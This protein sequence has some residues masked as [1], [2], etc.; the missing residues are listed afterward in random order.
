MKPQ[1]TISILVSDRMDTLEKCLNSITPILQN[2]NSELILVLTGKDPAV[3]EIAGQYTSHIIPFTWCDDFAEARNAGLREAEGEWFL[4]LD[5]D[6]WFEDTTEIIQFF[7]SGEYLN[8]QSATY[9]VRNYTDLEGRTYNDAQVSRMCRLMPDTRFMFPVHECLYPFQD[10][11]KCLGSYVHHFGYARNRI[12]EEMKAKSERN[13]SILLKYHAQQPCVHS[14]MQLAQEY[15]YVDD[16]PTAIEY[17][18]EGLRLAER[19]E[20]K[21]PGELWMQVH[22][23]LML[24][25]V[26][27]EKEAL[28]EGEQLL[29]SP[30]VLEVGR[31]NLHGILASLCWD[32]K[33]YEKGLRHVRCLRDALNCLEKHPKKA[34]QQAS[35]SI[36]YTTAKEHSVSAYIAGLFFA[37]EMNSTDRLQEILT[38]LPWDEEDILQSRYDN[39]E[40]LKKS[41]P[42]L[43]ESILEGYSRIQ[44]DNV[45][46][47]LQ[48]ALYAEKNQ[49]LTEAEE[50]FRVCAGNCPSVFIYQ[51][52]DLAK[53]NGFPLNPL[54]EHIPIE[55]WDEYTK[56]LA[57]N[58]DITGMPDFLQKLSPLLADYPV[59]ALRMEQRFLEKQ[60]QSIQESAESTRFTSLLEQYCRSIREEAGILYKKEL[61]SSADCYVLPYKYRFSFAAEKILENPECGNHKDYRLFLRKA[62]CIFPQ[63][64]GIITYL[65]K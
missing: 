23:P 61:L 6:E 35:V 18:R 48:K 57:E 62:R 14:C 53:R 37:A 51:L 60:L 42:K 39:L 25:A 2:L 24:S 21:H 11:W 27:K 59:C 44:T 45:Y 5:D 64:S 65:S 56:L 32:I 54:I 49:R 19:E 33:E 58:L 52:V 30:R 29:R 16:E 15:R 43:E 4:Y 55:T 31:A 22:L 12:P 9:I 8:F 10:S 3:R 46:V 38:W 41:Y 13:I 17:C 7:Q 26:G 1:L 47:T 28:E 50:F 34:G 36:S 20:K 40:Q 63:M